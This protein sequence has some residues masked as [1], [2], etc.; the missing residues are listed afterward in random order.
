MLLQNRLFT[1]AGTGTF[2]SL[3]FKSKPFKMFSSIA[4]RTRYLDH[5]R[6]SWCLLD[7]INE[8]WSIFISSTWFLIN[9]ALNL[10]TNIRQISLF[11]KR[12]D[13]ILSYN[14]TKTKYIFGR[15]I[16]SLPYIPLYFKVKSRLPGV[17]KLIT[18]KF[19]KI[20]ILKAI[21][22]WGLAFCSTN[23]KKLQKF[24]KYEWWQIVHCCA[25]K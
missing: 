18:E 14:I 7:K 10:I 2:H 9:H 5:E 21:S 11:F 24:D 12:H 6:P 3:Q 4:G 22:P 19:A 13:R 15:I 23:L 8:N 17:N 25:G 20:A 16:Y 1:F